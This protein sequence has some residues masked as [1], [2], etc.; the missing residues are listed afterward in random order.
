MSE[1]S[2]QLFAS[3]KGGH[4]N[5]SD[6]NEMHSS[7][8]TFTKSGE[9]VIVPK[10]DN[11]ILVSAGELYH[12]IEDEE[13][14]CNQSVKSSS[15]DYNLDDIYQS[16]NSDSVMSDTFVPQNKQP[17][18]SKTEVIVTD[19]DNVSNTCIYTVEV[20]TSE[21][22]EENKTKGHNVSSKDSK[23]SSSSKKEK[24]EESSNA[25]ERGSEQSQVCEGED[26][27]EQFSTIEMN[28]SEQFSNPTSEKNKPK[29]F[30]SSKQEQLKRI[31]GKS[32]NKPVT[33]EANKKTRRQQR[34][35]KRKYALEQSST[36]QFSVSQA[37]KREESILSEKPKKSSDKKVEI[38]L[39]Y[40]PKKEYSEKSSQHI[41]SEISGAQQVS[42]T[43]KKL[44]K[45]SSADKEDAT[46]EIH[47]S[48]EHVKDS[49]KWEEKNPKLISV[50]EKQ[51]DQFTA[52]SE[53]QKEI[54]TEISNKT[55]DVEIEH[56]SS[57]IV[58]DKSKHFVFGDD[59][60]TDERKTE[61]LSVTKID[62]IISEEGL[63][64]IA[65][66]NK[67]GGGDTRLISPLAKDECKQLEV[68]VEGNICHA[69]TSG[70]N[71]SKDLLSPKTEFK[72]SFEVKKVSEKE[73]STIG[74]EKLQSIV[75]EK[76]EQKE[77]ESLTLQEIKEQDTSVAQSA[78]VEDKS[79]HIHVVKIGKN[80]KSRKQQ[81]AEMKKSTAEQSGTKQFSVI[82]EDTTEQSPLSEK[83]Q[84]LSDEK[85]ET[86]QLHPSKKECSEKLTIKEK[87]KPS[88][89]TGSEVYGAQ[90]VSSTHKKISKQLSAHE[91]EATKDIHVSEEHVEESCKLGDEKPKLISMDDKQID[92]F[93]TPTE[94]REEI[95]TE[96]SSET[97][98][99]ETEH[100]S[101]STV[102]DKSKHAV[103][104][105]A[106]GTQFSANEEGKYLQ[107][108]VSETDQSD[109]LQ[110][111]EERVT[112]ELLISHVE[113]RN[114][115]R[116]VEEDI[117]QPLKE[118]QTKKSSAAEPEEG[119][120]LPV[121]RR[122]YMKQCSSTETDVVK[123]ETAVFRH[124]E[125]KKTR[126]EKSSIKQT[127]STE[128]LPEISQKPSNSYNGSF[129]EKSFLSKKTVRKDH[130][131]KKVVGASEQTTKEDSSF[132]NL[133]PKGEKLFSN[134]TVSDKSCNTVDT[135]DS[136]HLRGSEC[137]F[138]V[139]M[140]MKADENELMNLYWMYT[141][142][143]EES[144]RTLISV[145][146]K[147]Q[148]FEEKICEINQQLEIKY[149][150]REKTGSNSKQDIT[151]EVVDLARKE[152]FRKSDPIQK[153]HIFPYKEVNLQKKLTFNVIKSNRRPMNKTVGIESEV[154]FKLKKSVTVASQTSR[155]SALATHRMYVPL[156][157]TTKA[158][159]RVCR[160]LIMA[161]EK[162]MECSRCN[163]ITHEMCLLFVS[164]CP[165]V[166]CDLRMQ[167]FGYSKATCGYLKI[168]R[169]EHTE[170]FFTVMLGQNI[171]FY[172]C[173]VSNRRQFYVPPIEEFL[174]LCSGY[175]VVLNPINTEDHYSFEMKF[176]EKG[177]VKK[178]LHVIAEAPLQKYMWFYEMV[179]AASSEFF[180]YRSD[181][182]G[183]SGSS[184]LFPLSAAGKLIYPD[185]IKLITVVR[186]RVNDIVLIRDLT[187]VICCYEG[188]FTFDAS[189]S[190]DVVELKGLNNVTKLTYLSAPYTYSYAIAETC[191]TRKR[192]MVQIN[193]KALYDIV[194]MQNNGNFFISAEP[195]KNLKHT[196]SDFIM[197]TDQDVI[198]AAARTTVLV[199]YLSQDGDV[200]AM[201]AVTFNSFIRCLNF[202]EE[203]TAIG[204]YAGAFHK[205]KFLKDSKLTVSS[206]ITHKQSN[207][208]LVRIASS[209][210]HSFMRIQSIYRRDHF[211]Y[212]IIVGRKIFLCLDNPNGGIKRIIEGFFGGVIH[213][214]HFDDILRIIDS[215]KITYYDFSRVN[216]ESN[217]AAITLSSAD[218]LQK[219]NFKD[220]YN[221]FGMC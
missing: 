166:G 25:E 73:Q 32:V 104:D 106:C 137:P 101:V 98:K 174:S 197:S 205:I 23:Q 185:E 57:S 116:L 105:E 176:L 43:Q 6:S 3:R 77:K 5:H 8:S 194:G 134:V 153:R 97:E 18:E 85:I 96:K 48:E 76:T 16:R 35:E 86:K 30:Q 187:F 178:S 146:K 208:K 125:E 7:T 164:P 129:F 19:F 120:F 56:S 157:D 210:P 9:E 139:T 33:A 173:N 55:D 175:D 95:H 91:K 158:N 128:K 131:F 53:I 20:A 202:I 31:S 15:N 69:T 117:T 100:S 34:R 141:S 52:Q 94:V 122:G 84:K 75:T 29:Q 28:R 138:N 219:L 189:N 114:E 66:K 203:D 184:L 149:N 169:S 165:Y 151:K 13:E 110:A 182:T 42:G 41:G 168:R 1:R 179:K 152:K 123:S 198:V 37:D 167:K 17:E 118:Y 65:N 156:F 113:K 60:I 38:K 22:S 64:V 143:T 26:F 27:K 218:I 171:T 162:R 177:C 188:L 102:K 59:S 67:L 136:G 61:E 221:V 135:F 214:E 133:M 127:E 62:K 212:F 204:V 68:I 119:E 90:Q 147:I 14:S 103:G 45:Q 70:H 54:D 24:A 92:Q 72:R 217:E 126:E 163:I 124:S 121:I 83:P 201:K 80:R 44:S 200:E 108:Y 195:I 220:A 36:K 191:I 50:D 87:Q 181:N 196:V 161:K 172:D 193:S 39:P 148:Y 40:P 79:G 199:I 192:N 183:A 81:Q 115:S 186:Y 47:V 63:Q 180:D 11:D 145:Q 144:I 142:A 71:T 206:L 99:E 150:E 190:E 46:K 215:D 82:K 89:Q 160:K 154:P 209:D 21:L 2:S 107:S 49:C 213:S 93:T 51:T 132:I 159:C 207:L 112:K 140:L 74:K 88:Q 58:E 216:S 170:T 111:P 78:P 12:N 4:N 10:E 211:E 109:Y 155:A 130:A